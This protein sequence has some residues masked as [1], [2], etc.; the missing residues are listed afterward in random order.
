VKKD[1]QP[2]KESALH[3]LDMLQA[4]INLEKDKYKEAIRCDEKFEDVKVIYLRIKELEKKAT[5]LMEF[6]NQLYL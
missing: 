5:I 2:T 6:I 3:E 1:F 4:Q